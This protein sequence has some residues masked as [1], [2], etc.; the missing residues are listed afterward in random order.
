MRLPLSHSLLFKNTLPTV[1][2]ALT[3]A[4]RTLHEAG[5]SD[6]R[7]SVEVLMAA[8]LGLTRLQVFLAGE[9]NLSETEWTSFS[10]KIYRRARQ[11]PVAYLTGRREFW[12]LDFE[13]NPSVLIPRPETELLVEETLKWLSQRTTQTTLVELGTGSGAIAVSVAKSADPNK[14]LTILATDL[15]GPAL[16]TAAANAE[17]QAVGKRISWVQGSWLD[18]FSDKDR[19]IDLLVSNPP[20]ISEEELFQ[21][22]VTVREYEPIRALW[23]GR[24]G[25]EAL[26]IILRQAGRQLKKGGRLILEIGETQGRDVLTLASAHQLA[27]ARIL[28]DY[29]GKERILSAGYYG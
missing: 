27:D 11:E 26:R 21:L 17:R 15:S 9:K 25:L 1:Q 19:W 24:D 22:P 13:V 12:S 29:S 2:E 5:L 8:V 4:G 23:G 7:L 6:A 16:K 18:P 3:W 10:E 14:P 28:K 20:Y